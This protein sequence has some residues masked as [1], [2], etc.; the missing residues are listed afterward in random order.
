VFW[1]AVIL[2]AGSMVL[3]AYPDL[4]MAQDNSI[5]VLYCYLVTSSVG[6]SHVLIPI[7]SIIPFTY[8]YVDELDKKAVYYSLIRCNK[9]TYYRSNVL[10]AIISSVLLVTLAVLIFVMICLAFGANT[11]TDSVLEGYYS[12]TFFQS[13]IEQGLS[14]RILLIHICAFVMFSIP[15]SLLSLV[16]SI[17]SKN[18]YIIIASPFILFMAVSYATEMSSADLLNPGLM[19]LKGSML[20]MSYGGLFYA[21]GYHTI[22]I[23]LLSLFY[24]YMSKRRFLHEGL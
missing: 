19:L 9:K 6:I 16:T 14:M 3:G 17:L 12:G 13:W 18:K 23:S 22:V 8:F 10:T 20:K 1:G 5:S 7:V 24:Y 15:W 2:L 4:K 11:Q 21:I